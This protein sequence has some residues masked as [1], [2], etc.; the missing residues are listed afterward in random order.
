LANDGKGV[1]DRYLGLKFSI[2]GETHYGWL[3]ISVQIPNSK[4]NGFNAFIT[5]YAY[6]TE[7]NTAIIAGQETGA[8]EAS[9][10]MQPG[11][12]QPSSSQ[13]AQASLGMLARGAEGIAIWRREENETFA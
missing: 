11:S 1:R 9:S 6:E 7:A 3:R 5:G 4:K 10:S 8:V 12:P 13:P 2:R